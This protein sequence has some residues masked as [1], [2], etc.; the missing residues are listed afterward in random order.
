ML[1]TIVFVGAALC[2]QIG[3]TPICQNISTHKEGKIVFSKTLT[4][5]RKIPSETNYNI[6]KEVTIEQKNI[7]P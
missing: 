4:D 6:E 2:I 7:H 1:D 5:W 3:E